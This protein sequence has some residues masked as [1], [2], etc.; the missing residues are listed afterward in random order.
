VG[1]SGD[2]RRVLAAVIDRI[3]SCKGRAENL[4]LLQEP[5]ETMRLGSLCAVGGFVP[6]SVPSTL[7]HFPEDLD[8]AGVHA[9]T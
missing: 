3:I 9:A 4:T 8:G 7:T 6:L 5:C 1:L 2:N